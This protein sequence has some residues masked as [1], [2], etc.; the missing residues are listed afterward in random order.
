MSKCEAVKVIF[1]VVVSALLSIFPSLVHCSL[2]LSPCNLQPRTK[3]N[4]KKEQ[5][6][7]SAKRKQQ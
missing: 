6:E 7:T 1:C 5:Q 3:R 4:E 2:S